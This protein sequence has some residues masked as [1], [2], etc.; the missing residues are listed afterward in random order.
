MTN[1][2]DLFAG[3]KTYLTGIGLIGLGIYQLSTGALEAGL[4]SMASGLGLIF[5]RRGAHRPA[6]P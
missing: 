5:A 4:A 6:V 2:L 1:P 3:W